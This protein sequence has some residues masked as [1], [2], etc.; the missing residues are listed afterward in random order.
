M[1]IFDGFNR[2]ELKYFLY[3]LQWCANFDVWTVGSFSTGVRSWTHGFSLVIHSSL[4]FLLL[5]L[6]VL[7]IASTHKALFHFLCLLFWRWF[8]WTQLG[9][10]VQAKRIAFIKVTSLDMLAQFRGHWCLLLGPPFTAQE[11]RFW[12]DLPCSVNTIGLV[13]V[14]PVSGLDVVQFGLTR[15]L[16]KWNIYH[17]LNYW[18]S[19]QE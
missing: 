6:A 2:I 16:T 7:W 17:V 5:T 14:L 11:R 10:A 1:C 12:R 9:N 15:D 4:D 3:R 8:L 19:L 18:D 13:S